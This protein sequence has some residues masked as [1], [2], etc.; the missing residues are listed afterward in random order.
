[1]TTTVVRA[2][3]SPAFLALVPHLLECTP[4]RSLVIV[5][6]SRGRSSGAMRVDLPPAGDAPTEEGVASTVIGMACKVTLT[7][8]VAIAVYTDDIVSGDGTLPHTGLVDAVRAR[9]DICG[10]RVVDAL[11]VGTD[12]WA[13]YLEPATRAHPL[14]EI[15]DAAASGPE[16]DVSADHLA[17]AELPAASQDDARRIEQ[18]LVDVEHA[19]SRSRDRRRLSPARRAAADAVAAEIADAPHLFENVV[20]LP[21]EQLELTHLA[22]LAFCLERP[23][24]RDVA[25]MQWA[26]DLTTGDAVFRAQTAFR[27][28]EPFPEDLARPMWGEGARPD[29]ARLRLALELCRNVASS[30]ARERRPGPLAACAWLAWASGRSTHAAAYTDAALEIDGAH[31]LSEIVRAMVDAGRLPEWVFERPTSPTGTGSSRG[32]RVP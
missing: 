24:L 29:P 2:T 11:V 8:A 22:A 23:A 31:G 15:Q 14:A 12:A 20:V 26:C 25:L 28:G 10:L 1:M 27:A 7:D 18:L 21:S 32:S 13:S 9:A 19:L 4:R 3:S 16:H 5:P 30:V 6:F 17:A